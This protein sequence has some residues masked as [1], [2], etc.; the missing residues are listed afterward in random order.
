M[1]DGHLQ[2]RCPV[3]KRKCWVDGCPDS[4]IKWGMCPS[5]QKRWEEEHP[6]IRTK[7]HASNEERFWIFVEESSTATCSTW[8]SRL[9]G[10]KHWLSTLHDA[11]YGLFSLALPNGGRKMI[12]AH[13]YAY[14]LK[15]GLIPNKMDLDHLCRVRTC[16]NTDH[17]EPV[18]GAVNTLRGEGFSAV[19]ARKTHCPEGHP[20]TGKNL[21]F[22]TRGSR[23]CRTCIGKWS[24]GRAAGVGKGGYQR[25]RTHCPEGHVYEGKNL[26][27]EE[28]KRAD[29]GIRHVRRCRTCRDEGNRKKKQRQSKNQS[30]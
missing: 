26:I 30:R 5:H 27:L 16:V 18:T 7:L 1:P 29:G 3:A 17:L 23:Q 28:R 25:E 8:G 19:N 22:G 21:V 4:A 9:S 14:Q 6:R 24:T 12:R 11:G 10:C 15:H 2:R 20:L 13:R